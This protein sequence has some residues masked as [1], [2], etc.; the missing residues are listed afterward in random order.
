MA[1]G[2]LATAD[3]AADTLTQI[4]Q[5]P[6]GYTA[7][8]LISVCNRNST[9][10]RIR[11]AETATTSPA[12]SEWIEYDALILPNEAL[13][14]AGRVLGE[15]DYIYAQANTGNVSINVNGYEE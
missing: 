15:G 9:P 6:A 12:G 14:R 4:Y 2:K 7:T 5:V 8:Y 3:L 11:L 1:S 10:I 13:E